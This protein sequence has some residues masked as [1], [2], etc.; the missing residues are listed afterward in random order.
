VIFYCANATAFP[1]SDWKISE[2]VNCKMG[3]RLK[4]VEKPLALG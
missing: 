1:M 4:N 2:G 3:R